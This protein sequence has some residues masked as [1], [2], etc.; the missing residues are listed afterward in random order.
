MRVI[1]KVPLL[2]ALLLL[3]TPPV[4]AREGDVQ[5]GAAIFNSRC[6]DVCHQTPAL[7]RLNPRQWQRVL[8]TMQTRMA[9]VGMDPLTE[10]EFALLLNY[11]SQ[12]R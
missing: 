3:S 2:L 7:G 9:S 5:A 1:V 6:A 10:E 8:T 11:L 12:G 4:L